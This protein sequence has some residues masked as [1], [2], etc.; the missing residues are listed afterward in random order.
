MLFKNKENGQTFL[1]QE[2]SKT[3]EPMNAIE[4]TNR[5]SNLNNS[6]MN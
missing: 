1:R 2:N 4:K 5:H 6:E 3:T